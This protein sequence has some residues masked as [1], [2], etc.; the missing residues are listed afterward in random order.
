MISIVILDVK[1]NDYVTDAPSSKEDFMK[2]YCKIL[3]LLLLLLQ[4]Q[5]GVL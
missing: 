3:T 5:H 2:T 1:H 4:K